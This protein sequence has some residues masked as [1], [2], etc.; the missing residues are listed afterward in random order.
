MKINW[1][2]NPLATTFTFTEE[3][4]E[5]FRLKCLIEDLYE[6][7]DSAHY[8]LGENDV[9][10]AKLE[11]DIW[12]KN[13]NSRVFDEGSYLWKL[14][15]LEHG[16]HCGDCTCVPMTCSKCLA[17]DILGISTISGLGKAGGH[18]LSGQFDNG[19]SIHQVILDLENYE[20]TPPQDPESIE[21]WE[22]VGGFDKHIPRWKEEA[23]KSAAWLRKY[24]DEHFP[25]G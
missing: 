11:Y 13:G 17:E 24:R 14:H 15:E 9:E 8:Y 5:I 19:K 25:E 18:N 3:E 21:R 7:L 12:D 4:K 2:Q 20:P 10:K 23:T 22:R 1:N 6:R 16:A